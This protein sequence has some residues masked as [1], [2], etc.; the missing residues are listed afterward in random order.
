MSN[1][2][3]VLTITGSS[4]LADLTVTGSASL[5]NLTV[6]GTATIGTLEVTGNAH[7]AGDLTV[8]GHFIT[9]GT[10]PTAAVNAAQA[11]STATCDVAG[12]DT[13]GTITLTS[14]GS[15]QGAGL[16][17]TVS[18]AKAFANAPRPVLTPTNGGSVSAGAYATAAKD[19]FTLNFANAPA[20][21][22]TYVF[23]YFSPQ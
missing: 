19:S 11:G 15:G 5:Q 13:S 16:Q 18:F 1:C 12:N 9:A 4:T 3:S 20:A 10:T 14:L 7:I 2:T 22:Q 23:N 8:G 21:G 17:G 6:V